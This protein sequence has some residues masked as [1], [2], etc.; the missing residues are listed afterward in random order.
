MTTLSYATRLAF[1]LFGFLCSF[2]LPT[3]SLAQEAVVS[4]DTE[5]K[6]VSG[7]SPYRVERN[8]VYRV[9]GNTKIKADLYLPRGSGTFPLVMLVHGGAW[10][11]GDK[12]ELTPI[13]ES[14]AAKE[15]AVINVNYRLAPGSQMP[16]QVE[17]C[18]S[19]ILWA[20]ENAEDWSIDPSQFALWGYSAG[21]HLVS[22]IGLQPDKV[23]I[24][25]RCVIAGGPPCDFSFLPPDSKGMKLVMGATRQED[26]DLYLR[27][28]PVTYVHKD[29]PPF[30]LFHG[31]RDRIVPQSS[32][33]KLAELLSNLGTEVEYVS[34]DRKGHI[35]TFLDK[36][37]RGQAIEFL[38]SQLTHETSTVRPRSTDQDEK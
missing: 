37:I 10:S 36:K 30:F 34:V 17:D 25:V 3:N 18:L 13:A 20:K 33:R 14:L 26:P 11:M 12:W 23:A 22:L 9:V 16:E 1:C 28:S 21:G 7:E 4:S 29:A 2:C 19:A 35:Q 38:T 31:N 27:F 15:M 32:S 5:A 24:P 6:D 8:L